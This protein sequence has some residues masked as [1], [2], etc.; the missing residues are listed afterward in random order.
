MTPSRRGALGGMLAALVVAVAAACGDDATGVQFEEITEVDYADAFVTSAND[1]FTVDLAQMTETPSGVWR[2]DLVV[3][4]GDSA[5]Y[6][7]DTL[8]VTYTGWLRDG[9]LLDEGTWQFILGDF[10]TAI[11]GWHY[12]MV[13]QQATG[14]RLAVIPPALAYGDQSIPPVYPGA[15]LVFHLQLDSIHPWSGAP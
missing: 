12:A 10:G 7:N 11:A 13:E 1:T 15:I 3:G 8:F 5:L 14:T 9:T 4:V 2:Q 6:V